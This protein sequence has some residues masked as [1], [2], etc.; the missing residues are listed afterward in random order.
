MF[1]YTFGFFVGV[2]TTYICLKGQLKQF[3]KMTMNNEKRLERIE[4]LVLERV[5][6]EEDVA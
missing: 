2:V 1:E 5:E 6:V 3:D 4:A